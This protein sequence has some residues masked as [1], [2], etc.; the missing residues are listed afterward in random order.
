MVFASYYMIPSLNRVLL[1]CSFISCRIHPG[2]R[3]STLFAEPVLA[4][5]VALWPGGYAWQARQCVGSQGL[6]D[7]GFC[8]FLVRTC[9]AFFVPAN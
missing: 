7:G 3:C 1:M 8:P 6:L 2:C 5:N 4:V 9:F